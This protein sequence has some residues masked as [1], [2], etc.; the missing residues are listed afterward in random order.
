MLAFSSELGFAGAGFIIILPWL[1][2]HCTNNSL[3]SHQP[4]LLRTKRNVQLATFHQVWATQMPNQ[5][6]NSGSQKTH[7]ELSSAKPPGNFL[8][9]QGK[10]LDTKLTSFLASS[11]TDL[12]LF[13]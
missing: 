2:P 12:S 4:R 3:T 5:V 8:S 1:S 10:T 6:I 9:L 7:F 13:F 11:Y